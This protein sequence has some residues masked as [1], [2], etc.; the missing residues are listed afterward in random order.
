MAANFW[1]STQRK[2]WLFTKDEL[3]T[4]RQRLEDEDPANLAQTFV[5]PDIRLVNMYLNTMMSKLGKRLGVRQQALATA[6]VYLKR[7]YTCVEMRRTNPYLL[8]ATALYL[9]CKMEECPHHIRMVAQEARQLW[10]AELHAWDTSKLGECEFFLI[11]EMNSQLIVHQPYRT[12]T[13]LQADFGMTPDEV[14]L[15]WYIINDSYMTDLPLLFAPHIIALTAMLLALV[16]R[17]PASNSG[18][19]GG[20]GSAA[21]G[22]GATAAALAQAQARAL[23]TG[24]SGPGTPSLTP[25]SSGLGGDGSAN[26]EGRKGTDAR[27]GKVQRF[28]A[29]LAESNIDIEA[30]VDCTQEFISF[31]ECYEAYNEKMIKEAITR[32]IKARGLDK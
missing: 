23:L 21:S 14:T 13:S 6:Q 11:S 17:P 30:M 9:A 31:Y 25:Q 16:L 32:F 20:G 10:A 1:E 28:A 7:F 27:L 2:H 5:L 4:V 12:L 24:M 22:M 15:A 3:A 29:W 8:M 18:Q 26:T 19:A